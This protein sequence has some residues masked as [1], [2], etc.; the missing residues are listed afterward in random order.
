MGMHVTRGIK[1]MILF[2]ITYLDP[3]FLT[4]KVNFLQ[5]PS[6]FLSLYHDF[7]KVFIMLVRMQNGLRWEVFRVDFYVFI[8]STEVDKSGKFPQ[9]GGFKPGSFHPN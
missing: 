7:F 2:Q 3:L 6:K 9:G 5:L 1:L 8:N 4:F